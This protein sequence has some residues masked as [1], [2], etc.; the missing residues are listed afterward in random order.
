MTSRPWMVALTSHPGKGPAGQATLDGDRATLH[1]K[2]RSK[3]GEYGNSVNQDYNYVAAEALIGFSW[4][5][6]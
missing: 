4:P 5:G 3:A 6:K 1:Q 2:L